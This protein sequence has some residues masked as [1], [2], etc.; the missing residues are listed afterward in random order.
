MKVERKIEQ[1]I[2]RFIKKQ[3]EGAEGVVVGLSG[4]IDSS[5]VASLCVRALGKDHVVGLCMP[6]KGVT[7]RRDVEDARQL[8]GQ[9]GI[10]F[11]ICP[12]TPIVNALPLVYTNFQEHKVSLANAKARARMM[13]LYGFANFND[14]RVVGT[15]NKSELSIGYFTKYG[16]GGVDF[17]PIGDLYKYQVVELAKYL[18]IPET[19]V[20]KAPTAGLWRGQTDE[21][22]LGMSYDELDRILEGKVKG[23]APD[24]VA[25]VR[26]LV[27]NAEHKRM[28]PS[29]CVVE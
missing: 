11:H 1:K 19:I 10:Q 23:S 14:F 2:S 22:E 9:L 28:M 21:G 17:L 20:G 8:A 12:I 24:K 25:R 6:E 29:V 27:E 3:T 5:V 7:L 13:I 26:E 16:D 18:G 4:G 15:G